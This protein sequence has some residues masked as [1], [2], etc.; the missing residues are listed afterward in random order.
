MVIV[1][2]IFDRLPNYPGVL[3]N[4]I[5]SLMFQL[6]KLQAKIMLILANKAF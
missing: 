6:T 2:R 4:T 5:R 1:V 3:Q